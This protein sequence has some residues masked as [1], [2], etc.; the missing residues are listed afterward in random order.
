MLV[1]SNFTTNTVPNHLGRNKIKASI[2]DSTKFSKKMT[3][4]SME[5]LNTYQKIQYITINFAKRKLNKK[6]KT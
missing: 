5:H 1:S 4:M 6:F 3:K 2:K